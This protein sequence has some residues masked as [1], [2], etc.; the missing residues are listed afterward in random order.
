MSIDRRQASAEPVEVAVLFTDI[1]SSTA[2]WEADAGAMRRQLA[3]HDEVLTNAISQCA[4][5]VVKRTGDGFLARFD[6][7]QDAAAAAVSAQLQLAELD[8]SAVGGLRIRTAVDVGPVEERDHDLYGPALN[9]CARVMD[10]A[11]GGQVLISETAWE[12]LSGEPRLRLNGEWATVDFIDL[13]LHRL[14]G[15]PVPSDSSRSCI[16]S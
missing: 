13:G 7:A 2:K 15:L 16:L 3:R 12:E 8:F 4:G 1:E 11:H 5:H 14:K 6:T 9:R 10:A